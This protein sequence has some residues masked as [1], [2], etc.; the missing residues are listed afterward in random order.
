MYHSISRYLS[1]KKLTLSIKNNNTISHMLTQR[2]KNAIV[3]KGI[4]YTYTQL[5]QFSWLYKEHI[6][7][8]VPK[9]GRI[10]MFSENTPEYIFAIYAA[11]RAEAIVVPVDVT[12]NEK[13]LKYIIDDC[14][15]DAIFVESSKKEFVNSVMRQIDGFSAPLITPNDIDYS[16]VEK[17]P[18]V[19]MPMGDDDVVIAIIYTSGTTG[20]P[21]GVMLTYENIRYNLNE[22][23]NGVAIFNIDSR[24]ILLLPLHH[25]F[26]F[27]GAL[28]APIL[29]GG[30]VY[31]AENIAP[32][33]ILKLLHEGK[34]TV[35]IGVP[36][37]YEALAKG[38][39][40]KINASIPAKILYKL[41]SLIGSRKL[42]KTLFKSVQDK[43]GGYMEFF[44]SGGAALPIETANVF[45]TLGFYVL[46]GYGMTECAPMI[47]F[48]R[49]GEW[50]IGY[51]GRL[52]EGVELRI[53]DSGE[54]CVKGP[55][56]M[57]GYYNRPKETAD[58]IRNGWLHTGDTGEFHPKYGVKITGRIKEIIVTSNGKN[59]NPAEIENLITQSSLAIKELAVFL[60]QDIL[61]AIVYP[62]MNVVR[63][64][65]GMTI[66][67]TIRPEIEEYNKNAMSYKRIKRFH[68]IS[69]ELPKTRLGKIQRFKLDD[70]INTETREKKTEDLSQKSETYLMLKKLID[71]EANCDARGDD[72]LE[73]DLALDSLGRISIIASI[74]E[75]FGVVINENEFDNLSTLNILSKYVEENSK[76]TKDSNISWDEIFKSSNPNIKLPKSGFVHWFLHNYI[77]FFFHILYIYK[78]SGKE[79][80]PT[81]P[82]I[83]VGNHRSAYDGVF[84]TSKLNWNIVSKTFFFAKDK[85]FQTML[86]QFVAKRNNI[87]LMDINSNIKSSLQQMYQVLNQGNNIIIFPEGTRSKDGE[88][89]AF[90]DSFAILSKSLNVPVVP[91]AIK[92][93]E[94]A[95]YSKVRVPKFLSKI[96]VQFL[97]PQ[98]PAENQTAKEFRDQIAAIMA[99]ALATK[100]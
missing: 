36:R 62:D 28:L 98:Y 27:A 26:P 69:Q 37:L 63:S 45:K 25:I 56:V 96:N 100:K 49:P 78:A 77:K 79:N 57:K 43:F 46:E 41:A 86:M 50:K 59:I 54:L 65:T 97:P 30:T 67:E 13:E 11:L 20:S 3:Y 42:S 73:I 55:N 48:T 16:D 22:I 17:M 52:L 88:M 40:K 5:L 75:R 7:L 61:Q 31:I 95:V 23:I 38:I 70:L 60:H 84:I 18:I 76:E 1:K 68:I 15:P 80:I 93:A 35:V 87:I 58:I 71:S 19:E 34:I 99:Q 21:K 72:H 39:M 10:L 44:V 83:F 2:D 81:T 9:G 92:G 64:N 33:T 32:E 66:E 14:R 47:A 74:E 29:S 12:S 90:K 6:C 24:V 4:S 85:H 94:A 8:N 89:K 53:E 91:I 82:C 51:C